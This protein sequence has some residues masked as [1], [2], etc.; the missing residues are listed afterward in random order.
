MPNIILYISKHQILEVFATRDKK[1]SVN[2]NTFNRDVK[3]FLLS[4][5]I[6]KY[7]SSMSNLLF[8]SE[9]MNVSFLFITSIWNLTHFHHLRLD[10]SANTNYIFS[11]IIYLLCNRLYILDLDLF[12]KPGLARFVIFCRIFSVVSGYVLFF[13]DFVLQMTDVVI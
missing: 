5:H 7:Y 3:M 9:L 6:R 12:I 4:Q 2:I 11:I 10:L 13:T 8:S 1:D